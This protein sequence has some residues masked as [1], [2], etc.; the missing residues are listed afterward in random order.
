MGLPFIGVWGLLGSDILKQRPDLKVVEDPFRP[1]R[2]VV[3][4]EAIRPDVSIL[5]ALKADP[6]GNAVLAGKQ[7]SPVMAQASKRVIVTAEEVVDRL[8][9][10]DAAQ[11]GHTFLPAVDADLVVKAPFGAHPGALPGAYSHDEAHCRQYADAARDRR[12]FAGYLE[13][14][15]FGV[16]DHDAYL[17]LVGLA[18]VAGR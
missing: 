3:V 13:R 5:H 15:V 18:V 6:E 12:A 11:E 16:P 2:H 7:E 10:V 1:G 14:F 9:P 4:A 8:T 17:A